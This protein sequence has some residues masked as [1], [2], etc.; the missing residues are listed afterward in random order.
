M[1]MIISGATGGDKSSPENAQGPQEAAW[2]RGGAAPGD[3]ENV[4]TAAGV[5]FGVT[6]F[7]RP[8]DRGSERCSLAATD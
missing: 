8:N 6:R 1:S 3:T 7:W 5:I 4:A 2:A